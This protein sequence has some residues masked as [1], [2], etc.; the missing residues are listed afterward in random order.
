MTKVA[1][2]GTE[3]RG[4]RGKPNTPAKMEEKRV[5]CS[6]PE[7]RAALVLRVKVFDYLE[8]VFKAVLLLQRRIRGFNKYSCVNKELARRRKG[9]LIMQ[10]P[11]EV[12]WIE[13]LHKTPV[14]SK[15][16]NGNN[17]GTQIVSLFTTTTVQLVNLRTWSLKAHID[18][19]YVI[20]YHKH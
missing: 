6:G 18:H 7:A 8:K 13:S 9:I 11:C 3:V 15:Q 17:C 20:V 12:A 16:A 10:R 14:V 5:V 19:W 2:P 1:I 4:L